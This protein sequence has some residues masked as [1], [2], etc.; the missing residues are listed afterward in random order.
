MFTNYRTKRFGFSLIELLV[1]IGIIGLLMG[2]LLPALMSARR[3]GQ[4]ARRMNNLRQIGA[5]YL[6]YADANNDYVPLGTSTLCKCGVGCAWRTDWND[7][8]WVRGE[9]ASAG[10]VFLLG[11]TIH[12]GNA[13]ILYCPLEADEDLNFDVK[14]NLFPPTKKDA[15]PGRT[16]KTSYAVRPVPKVWCYHGH[17]DPTVP[18]IWPIPMP[19]LEQFHGKVL[20]SEP[21]E[22]PPFNHGKPGDERIHALW[23]DGAV[24]LVPI[25]PWK[26]LLESGQVWYEIVPE[27]YPTDKHNPTGMPVWEV[28]DKQ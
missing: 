14:R 12:R 20:V 7:F 16:I 9:P 25:K 17:C 28:L 10:G 3:S 15:V 13:S 19:K 24:K 6:M 18:L 22:R 23:H 1:V 27:P 8:I 4:Q 26:P 5:F 21:P 11:G 2:L